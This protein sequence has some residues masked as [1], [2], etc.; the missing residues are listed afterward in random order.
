MNTAKSPEN[1]L[2]KG[3]QAAKA[4]FLPGLVVQTAVVLTLLGYAF[5]EPTREFL[6][7]LAAL[8]GAMG[9]WFAALSGAIAGGVL[10]ELLTI[11]VFQKGKV[12][13]ANWANLAFA[14]PFWAS[15]GVCVDFFYRHIDGISGLSTIS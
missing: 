5:H 8:K 9:F 3:W 13:R 10:P 4:N 12:T 1:P 15:Q 7:H 11:I 2:L 6:S 14:V